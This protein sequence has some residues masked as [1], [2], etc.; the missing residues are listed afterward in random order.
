[1]E[2]LNKMQIIEDNIYEILKPLRSCGLKFN[3]YDI[4]TLKSFNTCITRK[5]TLIQ[6]QPYDKGSYLIRVNKAMG[7]IRQPNRVYYSI[8]MSDLSYGG[9]IISVTFSVNDLS[10]LHLRGREVWSNWQWSNF[11]YPFK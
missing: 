5:H 9:D 11:K 8:Q 7:G 1:M 3:E 2:N 10:D 4:E 6:R